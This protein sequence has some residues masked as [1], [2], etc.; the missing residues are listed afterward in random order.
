MEV[1]CNDGDLI[2]MKDVK[3][4]A[5][6]VMSTMGKPVNNARSTNIT[7][8]NVLMATSVPSSLDRL[9]CQIDGRM[10]A[11]GETVR[12]FGNSTTSHQATAPYC[13]EIA[14]DITCTNGTF[15]DPKVGIYTASFL[16][17]FDIPKPTYSNAMDSCE[18]N[19]MTLSST[20][21]P[22][23][24]MKSEVHGDESCGDYSNPG[25][26]CFQGK[27]WNGGGRF[28]YKS[29][30]SDRTVKSCTLEGVTVPDGGKITGYYYKNATFPETCDLKSEMTCVD[31]KLSGG[32][33][34][35]Y[36]YAS[37]TTVRGPKPCVVGGQTFTLTSNMVNLF[38]LSSTYQERDVN[39]STCYKSGNWVQ[40]QC[41]DGTFRKLNATSTGWENVDSDVFKYLSCTNLGF[42]P[43]PPVVSDSTGGGGGGG[44]N[45]DS[46]EQ[47]GA[48]LSGSWGGGSSTGSTSGGGTHGGSSSG[49]GSSGGSSGGFSVPPN[50]G[51]GVFH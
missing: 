15:S 44:S 38:R 42:A 4:N 3:F 13:N 37:C 45:G 47:A 16:S 24:Y 9:G 21:K 5:A 33:D 10:V 7:T 11:H 51:S 28:S 25:L 36:K 20:V 1:A 22:V 48:A 8:Y 30:T 2:S 6:F 50:P 12:A 34:S 17:C 27:L 46:S 32:N 26:S 19:G 49:G 31:G 41:Y 35:T 43:P 18:W 29:C 40:A 39:L 14:K 23:G